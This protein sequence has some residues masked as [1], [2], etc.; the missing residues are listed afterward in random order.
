M[1]PFATASGF[2]YKDFDP[3]FLDLGIVDG[4]LHMLPAQGDIITPYVK[5]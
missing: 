4:E 2:P 3:T 1:I 5:K